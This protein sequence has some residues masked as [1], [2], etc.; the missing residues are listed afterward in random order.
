MITQFSLLIF[1]K[2]ENIFNARF[3]ILRREKMKEYID[4]FSRILEI[5]S[6]LTKI[7]TKNINPKL[8]CKKMKKQ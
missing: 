7:E 6:N 4:L 5:S 1:T 3:V 2:N 8:D